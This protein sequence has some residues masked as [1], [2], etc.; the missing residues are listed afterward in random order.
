MQSGFIIVF[1]ASL[2]LG[3]ALPVFKLG[4]INIRLYQLIMIV[5]FVFLIVPKVVCQR[6]MKWTNLTN[7]QMLSLILFICMCLFSAG[8]AVY[9]ILALKQMILL[10]MQMAGAYFISIM[11]DTQRRLEMAI[12]TVRLTALIVGIYIAVIALLTYVHTGNPFATWFAV[13]GPFTE[14]NEYGIFLVYSLGYLLPVFCLER[15]RLFELAV[16]LVTLV[17]LFLLL[18]VN[19]SRGSYV[20]FM[21]QGFILLYGLVFWRF[22][23]SRKSKIALAA[24]LVLLAL[25]TIAFV[26]LLD[27]LGVLDFFVERLDASNV[28]DV[29][30]ASFQERYLRWFDAIEITLSQ[31][32]T[33]VGLGNMPFYFRGYYLFPSILL[34]QAYS[35]MPAFFNSSLS[36][37]VVET[38]LET[39]VIGLA[40][41]LALL[42]YIY[43]SFVHHLKMGNGR[44]KAAM[45]ASVLSM[46]GLLVNGLSYNMIVLPF[47]WATVGIGMASVNII[48]RERISSN[49]EM[50]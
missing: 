2:G 50:T 4:V 48:R 11:I 47:F 40:A 5:G 3:A 33:G 15:P 7:G 28:G 19:Y 37:F 6:K 42:F 12:W 41:F 20:G 21:F 24:F 14:R 36:N 45:L 9:P 31:P 13:V 23:V 35:E 44:M 29:S 10:S 26:A 16:L 30:Q 34:G 27:Q 1:L 46:A 25:L 39:G 43:K 22:S 32:L 8:W 38:A 18:V 49:I 17:F